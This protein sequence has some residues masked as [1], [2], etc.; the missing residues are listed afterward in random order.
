MPL[1]SYLDRRPAAWTR[2]AAPSVDRMSLPGD[3]RHEVAA[4][5]V[6]RRG[7]EPAKA[8]VVQLGRAH[9]RIQAMAP[10]RFA[11]I[12]VADARADPLFQKQLSKSGCLG[13]T[14][15]PD[16]LLEVERIDQDIR[17]EVRD[18]LSGIANQLHNG[19]GEADRHHILETQHR[20]GAPLR[21]APAF[22]NAVEVPG[23][24]HAHVRMK[25]EPSLEL[26]HEVFAVWLDRLDPPALQSPDRCRT[27]VSDYL[28]ADTAP[29][30][31]RRSPDRV[32]FRQARA[33]ALARGRPPSAWCRTRRLA[34]APR[35]MIP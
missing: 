4:H 26:H 21:L 10:E 19:R 13:S 14:G 23:A 35:L 7:I 6:A 5:Q 28:A 34:A 8:V 32:A 33:D 31:G 17:S 16:D 27:G 22:A 11:L 1:R 9:P 25:G 30:R 18:W 15:T 3:W 29:Q 20:G 12:D 24:G 2:S